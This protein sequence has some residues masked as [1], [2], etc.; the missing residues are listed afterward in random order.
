MQTTGI[1]NES[2]LVYFILLDS[3]LVMDILA[4]R[5]AYT[6][7]VRRSS[8]PWNRST[9]LR[10]PSTAVYGQLARLLGAKSIELFEV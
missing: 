1:R 10:K 2:K 4:I 6:S 9:A 5:K 7:H 8:V 3:I